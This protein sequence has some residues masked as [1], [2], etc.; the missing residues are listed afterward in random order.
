MLEYMSLRPPRYQQLFSLTQHGPTQPSKTP[1]YSASNASRPLPTI[2]VTP[3]IIDHQ[4]ANANLTR[5]KPQDF[6]YIFTPSS[7]PTPSPTPQQTP[8]RTPLTPPMT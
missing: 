6:R 5:Y 3:S 7:L 1:Q 2:T 4:P 8:P